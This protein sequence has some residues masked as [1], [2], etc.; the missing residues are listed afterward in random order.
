MVEIY[1]KKPKGQ[2]R[3]PFLKKGVDEYH[4]R[5]REVKFNQWLI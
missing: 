4:P 3:K 5:D 1:I 2:Q